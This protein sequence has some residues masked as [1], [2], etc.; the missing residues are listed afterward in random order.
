MPNGVSM[1]LGASTSLTFV[2]AKIKAS[3]SALR[4]KIAINDCADL[5]DK[6]ED[7]KSRFSAFDEMRRLDQGMHAVTGVLLT[8]AT[9]MAQTTIRQG[10]LFRSEL[11]GAIGQFARASK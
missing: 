8:T 9:A 5:E 4:E 3:V 1:T 7:A 6:I 11:I 2:S 10:G